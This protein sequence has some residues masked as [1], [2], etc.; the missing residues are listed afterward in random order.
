[1]LLGFVKLQAHSC[2]SR[3]DVFEGSGSREAQSLLEL[4]YERVRIKGI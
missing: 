2:T 1:V 3:G 4:L